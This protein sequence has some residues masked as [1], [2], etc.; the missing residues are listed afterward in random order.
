VYR[1]SDEGWDRHGEE[2]WSTMAELERQ[3]G[4]QEAEPRAPVNQQRQAYRQNEEDI[5]RMERYYDRRSRSYNLYSEVYV[6]P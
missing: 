4:V 5:E 2:G 1:R 6:R 3:Y